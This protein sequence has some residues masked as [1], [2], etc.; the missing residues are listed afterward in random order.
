MR[1][2]YFIILIV[3]FASFWKIFVKAGRQGWEGIIPIYN[4]YVLLLILNKPIWW[5]ILIFIPIAQ[6]VVGFLLSMALAER[7]GKSTGFAVGMFFLP[8]IFYPILAFGDAQYK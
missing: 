7:F 8:F 6:L 4:C 5:L 2:I 1:L 3:V